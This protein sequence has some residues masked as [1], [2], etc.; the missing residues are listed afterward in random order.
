MTAAPGAVVAVDLGGTKILA[1]V[2]DADHRVAGSHK[3]PTPSQ[4]PDAVV[5]AIVAAVAELDVAPAA[6]GVGAPGPVSDGV[7]QTAPNLPG[8]SQPVPL[9]ARLRAELGVPVVVGNDVT[10][11]TVGEWVAGAGRGARSVLGVILGTGVGGGLVL[12]GRPYA[13]AFGGAGEFGHVVVRP[14]GA[15]CG[16]GRRGCVEAYA[17][18]ASMERAL[19]V[20]VGAGR[21]TALTD[22]AAR[23]G[24]DRITSSVWRSALEAGD[25]VAARLIG[26]AVEAVGLGVASAVNLLD[27]DC[28]V[29]GGGLAEQLGQDIADRIA[30][31]AAPTCS[32]PTAVAASSSPSS[33][34]SPASSAPRTS[35]A[36]P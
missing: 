25:E 5:A 27:L 29:V 30:A 16:C 17:G 24:K 19:D 9:A 20:L 23:R 36:A 4:G 31:A 22:I 6:V 12:D 1:A 28:V 26:E 32:S 10:A 7:V 3:R 11:G 21:R 18:R 33:A 8:W 34:T 14:G 13:G 35:P 15:L 2:V